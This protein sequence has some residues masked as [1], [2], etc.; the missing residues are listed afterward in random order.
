MSKAL[1]YY[2]QALDLQQTA[3]DSV[4]L[5]GT[6]YN[7]A[8]V[9]RD[10]GNLE[11]A[12]LY[13]EQAL[14][15]TESL[16]GK[17]ASRDLRSSFVASV[18]Q[19]YELTVDLLMQMHQQHPSEGYAARAFGISERARARSLL[20]SLAETGTETRYAANPALLE[21]RGQL[22]QLL[23]AKAEQQMR[24]SD[25]KSNGTKDAALTLE[26]GDLTAQYEQVQGQ[27][28][29]ESPHYAAL[30]QV[31]PLSLKEVQEQILDEQSLLLEFALGD[32]QSYLWA[33]TQTG[34]T[35]H[36]LPKRTEID[37]TARRLYELLT[38]RQPKPDETPKQYQARV[39]EAEAQYWQ[40]AAAL[41]Q[42]LL[43]PVA[44]QLGKR[45]LLIVAEGA[46]QY[47]PFGALP[48]RRNKEQG[49]RSKG[50]IRGS[51]GKGE[52]SRIGT[53]GEGGHPP[54]SYDC[55][56]PQGGNFGTRARRLFCASDC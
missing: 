29:S 49:A 19:Q 17:V 5:P 24:L 8:R 15:I 34:M 50:N 55:C 1:E 21:R 27:I 36:H 38:A 9:E 23:N 52:G 48:S 2:R 7:L 26:I 33:V 47:I 40:Q 35:C 20:E 13:A 43:G 54:Q 11:Q 56:P 4:G 42:V 30:A 16:R 18:H 41:S 44:D 46:L 39:K 45:R 10:L 22:Q 3:K 32:D 12:I 25:N 53:E 37:Q 6:L 51:R 14:E 31:Q 28:R